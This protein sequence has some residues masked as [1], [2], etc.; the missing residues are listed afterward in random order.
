M[1]KKLDFQNNIFGIFEFNY[2]KYDY[3]YLN[4]NLKKL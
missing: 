4:Y 2:M 3:I 1:K